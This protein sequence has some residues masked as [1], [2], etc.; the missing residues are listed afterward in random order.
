M[1]MIRTGS[2]LLIALMVSGCVSMS[3]YNEKVQEVAMLR[4]DIPTLEANLTKS[5]AAGKAL[6][7]EL[8][9]NRENLARLEQEHENLKAEY[10]ALTAEKENANLA[11]GDRRHEF[12]SDME[13]LT[14]RLNESETRVKELTTLL[15][16]QEEAAKKVPELQAAVADREERISNLNA[17]LRSLKSNLIQIRTD[18]VQLAK[19][20]SG[21]EEKENAYAAFRRD[22]S[23]QIGKGEILV[24]EYPDKLIVTMP[25]QVLFRSGSATINKGGKKALERVASIL[26]KVKNNRIRIEGHTDST[27]IKSKHRYA[28]NWDL[29]AA[30][31]ASVVRHL[32][33]KGA[34]NPE[35]LTLAGYGPY[36]PAAANNTS[37]GRSLNRRIEI[38]LI[39]M[40]TTV[41]A[42][43]NKEKLA[44][45]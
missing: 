34:V 31:A 14:A 43:T 33:K 22:F 17:T 18:V 13:A 15:L 8:Q 30:R 12:S 36:A 2:T 3:K 11:M 21:S 28:S 32:Q 5:E 20:R 38:A 16:A 10:V 24:T 40:D 25:E 26:K 41:T 6:Q 1:R 7:G 39:P 27:P 23:D 4:G 45:R 42:E 29:S 44:L 35:F 19:K 37:R 9:K